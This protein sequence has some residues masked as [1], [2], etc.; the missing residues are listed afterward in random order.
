M[1]STAPGS[2]RH[3]RRSTAA[4]GRRSSS[5]PTRTG[6]P[7]ASAASRQ[8]SSPVKTSAY[9]RVNISPRTDARDRL[10]D[11]LRAR[12]EVAQ[13]RRRCRRASWPIGSLIEVDVHPA[14]ERVGDHERRRGEVVRLHL[15]M[16]ARL[17]VPVAREHG[18]RRRGRPR[19][20]RSR[21]PPAA[22]PSSRC[23]SCSR[24]RPCLKPSA[25]RYVGQAGL[26]VVL[27]HDLRARREARLDPR[28]PAAA[29]ARRPSSPAGRRRSSPAG[30]TCSCTR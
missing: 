14:G 7:R 13:D 11:L 26:L 16:D 27:G 20:S 1:S 12:P 8:A 21:S 10:L 24:S 15:G 29:R 9:V 4:A 22:A 19:R 30:S 2:A 3:A 17:E 25:S 18:A 6:R 23:R 5:G 28:L